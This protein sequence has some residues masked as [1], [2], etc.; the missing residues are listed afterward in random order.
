MRDQVDV[1][2]QPERLR[3]PTV[4]PIAP[5]LPYSTQDRADLR[6]EPVTELGDPRD[7]SAIPCAGMMG[8]ALAT[9]DTRS[10]DIVAARRLLDDPV[11][12]ETLAAIYGV[13]PARV[14]QIEHA[15]FA[16]VQQWMAQHIAARRAAYRSQAA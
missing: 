8:A 13:T 11:C 10:R 16:S 3:G 14:R 1:I 2:G 9:L 7:V 12:L 5:A 15:A 4:A 6:S